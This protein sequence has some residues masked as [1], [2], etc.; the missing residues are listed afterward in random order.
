[1][2]IHTVM[3]IKAAVLF[4][5]AKTHSLWLTFRTH[6]LPQISHNKAQLLSRINV[7]FLLRLTLI[8]LSDSAEYQQQMGLPV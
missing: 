5:I 3:C 4:N 7:T 1:M 6:T 2:S 8:G